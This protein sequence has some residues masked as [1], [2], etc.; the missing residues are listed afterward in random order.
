M[1]PSPL[2]HSEHSKHPPPPP[3]RLVLA[4]APLV[5][6][7]SEHEC[8]ISANQAAAR[9]T[10]PAHRQVVEQDGLVVDSVPVCV[11]AEGEAVM[12]C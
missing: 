8:V 2:H 1:R 12:S 3:R 11:Q 6:A 10:G 4:A 9:P 7:A 5:T